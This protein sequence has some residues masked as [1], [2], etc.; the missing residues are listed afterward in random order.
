MSA[1]L[2]YQD[3]P[4]AA[5][6]R[7]HPS[8]PGARLRHAS[9]VDSNRRALFFM[10]YETFIGLRHLVAGQHRFLNA[11]TMLAIAGV[12]LGVAAF[13]TVVSVAGGFVDAFEDRV[14][15][16][17]PHI[18]VSKYGIFF[19]EYDQVSDAIDAI[20]G[21][22]STSPFIIREMLITSRTSRARPGVLVKGV[23]TEAAAASEEM[24]ELVTSGSLADLAYDGALAEDPGE[25]R[26]DA[27]LGAL[28]AE[29]LQVGVGD[30]VTLVSPLRGLRS[31]GV[32]SENRGAD[33]AYA[34]VAAIVDTGYFDYDNRLVLMDVHAVQ[35]LL[36]MGD[37]VMGVEVRL[38]D[39][40][41]VDSVSD[42][43]DG[44][45]TTGRF[46]TLDWRE[47]NRNLFSSLQLQKLALTVVMS[48]LVVVAS[49][50]ILCVLI[51]LV[52]EKRREIAILRSM[53]ATRPA[54]LRV[55][56]VQGMT[57]GGLGTGIGLV[58]GVLACLVLAAVDYELAYEVYRVRSLPVD[59]QPLE[60]AAAAVGSLFICFLATLY[61]AW[62]AARVM[63]VEALRYD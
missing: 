54:I 9:D 34:R 6:H 52:L 63:P 43:I 57:I 39:P 28:L 20:D 60:F 44:V 31:V 42:A 56:L 16:V 48:V 13:V 14:L 7:W 35:D 24:V 49:S 11:L 59:M 8:V 22:E 36:G 26:V 30:T 4:L 21:V 53:G 41:A 61:P 27:A 19:P 10:R 58:L 23:E 51:M 5:I 18:M 55:F 17:N 47:L 45:L 1:A 62:R 25:A 37:V 33:Y 38:H 32:R 15:G 40:R 46:K 50:V 3:P 29:K 12:A 2:F